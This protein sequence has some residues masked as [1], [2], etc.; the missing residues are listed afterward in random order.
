M[1]RFSFSLFT[2]QGQIKVHMLNLKMEHFFSL[3]QLQVGAEE[4]CGHPDL[5]AALPSLQ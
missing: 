1:R 3:F 2:G 5:E 4:I